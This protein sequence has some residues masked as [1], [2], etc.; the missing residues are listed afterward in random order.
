MSWYVGAQAVART[1][2]DQR[3]KETEGRPHAGRAT[4]GDGAPMVLDDLVGQGEPEPGTSLLGR[5]EGVEDPVR[6]RKR[7]AV[8]GIFDLD[9]DA[10]PRSAPCELGPVLVVAPAGPQRQTA[11]GAHRLQ[12]VRDE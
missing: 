10:P 6:G 7:D 11:A 5:E 1:L 3:K 12:R 2:V 8:S 4:E 9:L